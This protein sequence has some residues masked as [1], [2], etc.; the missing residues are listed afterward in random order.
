MRI[1]A[2]FAHRARVRDASRD[3]ITR[4]AR[5]RFC[6][7]FMSQAQRF[8]KRHR[9]RRSATRQSAVNSATLFSRTRISRSGA[10]TEQA[11]LIKR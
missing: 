10:G 6:G 1:A 7:A 4:I 8:F 9:S 5:R 3:R 2:L 11:A